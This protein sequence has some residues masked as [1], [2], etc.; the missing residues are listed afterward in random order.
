MGWS[1]CRLR[2][3][4]WR[5]QIARTPFVRRSPPTARR[6]PEA[7]LAAPLRARVERRRLDRPDPAVPRESRGATPVPAA[8]SRP[9]EIAS[10]GRRARAWRR[11][12]LQSDWRAARRSCARS[13][14]GGPDPTG[15]RREPERS[16]DRNRVVE[17]S[18]RVDAAVDDGR[19][20]LLVVRPGWDDSA[21]TVAGHDADLRQNVLPA[22]LRWEIVPEGEPTDGSKL[23]GVVHDA[24]AHPGD[25]VEA[26]H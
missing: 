11:R 5:C 17:D 18:R 3:A 8:R 19:G 10:A 23:L 4:E 20:Q 6:R 12:N 26:L 24:P 7:R 13:G 14:G 2:G 25:S 15:G 9:R 1:F 16:R 21:P 22:V